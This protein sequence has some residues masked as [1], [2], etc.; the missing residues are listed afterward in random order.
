MR[1]CKTCPREGTEKIFYRT[2]ERF[3]T[4]K[5]RFCISK[6]RAAK[7]LIEVKEEFPEVN[8]LKHFKERDLDL[9]PGFFFAGD[10]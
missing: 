9:F 6:E 7:K 10:I 5:C 3:F 8:P 2:G 4:R 1:K